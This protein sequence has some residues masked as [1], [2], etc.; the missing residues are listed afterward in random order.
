MFSINH[1]SLIIKSNAKIEQKL[2]SANFFD[3]NLMFFVKSIMTG[4]Y[5]AEVFGRA[6]AIRFCSAG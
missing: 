4:A 6:V 2:L 1:L 5:R 3:K